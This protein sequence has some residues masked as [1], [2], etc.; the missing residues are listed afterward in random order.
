[1]NG[2]VSDDEREN[3]VPLQR[4]DFGSVIAAL[5]VMEP[6]LWSACTGSG[7]MR[8]IA[9]PVASGIVPSTVLTLLVIAAPLALVTGCRL[10][11]ADNAAAGA[12]RPGIV[13]HAGE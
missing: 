10:P 13:R 8:R 4:S 12:R 11:R 3:R 9:A 5:I 7:V 2:T 1:M 6:I